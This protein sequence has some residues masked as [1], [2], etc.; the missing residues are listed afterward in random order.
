MSS[1]GEATWFGFAGAILGGRAGTRLVPITTAEYPTP[2]R[3]PA[4]GVFDTRKFER[5][6]GFALPPWRTALERCLAL[7]R[8]LSPN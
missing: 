1:T 4:Y 3:R 6:F 7:Q 2:A 8:Q 5:T